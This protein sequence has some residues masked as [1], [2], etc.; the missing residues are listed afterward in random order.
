MPRVSWDASVID[1]HTITKRDHRIQRNFAFVSDLS[2]LAF[3]KEHFELLG[4]ATRKSI[5]KK[6]VR[7]GKSCRLVP[8]LLPC[9]P[10]SLPDTDNSDLPYWLIDTTP[11]ILYLMA[12][13]DSDANCLVGLYECRNKQAGV[14][15]SRMSDAAA[16]TLIRHIRNTFHECEILN[17][18]NLRFGPWTPLPGDPGTLPSGAPIEQLRFLPQ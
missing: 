12:V 13:V 18:I 11:R 4:D 2:T 17:V 14:T 9:D 8:L 7:G 3:S 16:E 10:T 15:L 1:N 5:Q 6:L